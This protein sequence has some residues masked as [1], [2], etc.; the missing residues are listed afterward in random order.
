MDEQSQEADREADRDE[1]LEFLDETE[2]LELVEFDPSV[3][4][5][6]AWG[7][8]KAISTFLEKHFNRS[9]IEEE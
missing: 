8:P 5:K 2:A 9:L 6:E 3:E 1:E 7:L 4:L